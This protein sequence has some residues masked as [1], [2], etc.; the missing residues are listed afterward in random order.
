MAYASLTELESAFEARLNIHLLAFNDFK[1]I[2][3]FEVESTEEERRYLRSSVPFQRFIRGLKVEMVLLLSSLFAN[4]REEHQS[5]HKLLHRLRLSKSPDIES[6]LKRIPIA[7]FEA[8][9]AQEGGFTP[10]FRDRNERVAHIPKGAIVRS[11]ALPLDHNYYSEVFQLSDNILQA[12]A[13]AYFATQ[14]HMEWPEWESTTR[15]L[16]HQLGYS[17]LILEQ[18][19]NRHKS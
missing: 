1:D 16:S 5:Y 15:L 13:S 11:L 10:L 8:R 14:H 7:E 3:R 6:G 19:N 9:L 17:K 12:L 18:W 4:G 2:V